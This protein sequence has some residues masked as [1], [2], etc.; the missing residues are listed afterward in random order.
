MRL[1]QKQ[2]M[3]LFSNILKKKLTIHSGEDDQEKFKETL[4]F[5]KLTER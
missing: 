2:A 5:I 4:N 3:H 1:L